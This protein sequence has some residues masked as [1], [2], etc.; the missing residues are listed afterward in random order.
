MV[1]KKDFK[2]KY[3]QQSVNLKGCVLKSDIVFGE[4]NNY[5]QIGNAYLLFEVNVLNDGCPFEYDN[6]DVIKL[7]NN[8]FARLFEE[9]SIP[10]TGG[11]EIEINKLVGP[12]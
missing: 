6:T 10:K 9:A 11:S 1:I 3:H 5:Y 2:K 7:V 4:N 12:I 8:A